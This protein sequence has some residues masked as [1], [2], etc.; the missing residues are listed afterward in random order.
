[1]P[2]RAVTSLGFEPEARTMGG[3]LLDRPEV[4]Q[5]LFYPRREVEY[6]PAR[7]GVIPVRFEVAPQVQVGGRLYPASQHA[8]AILFFHG[9]GEIAADYDAISALYTRLGLTLLVVDYR[10]YGTSD[11]L[12]TSSNLLA[13]AL[14]IYEALSTV[15][16][17]VGAKPARLYVM[18]RS[19]GSAPAIEVARHAGDHLAGLIVESGFADTFALLARLGLRVQGADE[20]RDGF[21]NAVKMANI[22]IPTLIIH[23]QDDVLIPCTEGQELHRCS[24]ASDKRLALIPG[25]GHNDLLWVGQTQYLEALRSLTAP[26]AQPLP[27]R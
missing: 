22:Q 2:T 26:S 19:L 5:F 1:M 16:A 14:R 24:E 10:G 12:P 3:W 21:G 6:A 13:D 9:N 15:L 17:E 25:A 18:G 8:P 7:P 20:E 11:G 4:L 27:G 23:G